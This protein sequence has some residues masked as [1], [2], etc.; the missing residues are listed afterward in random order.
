MT[1]ITE[2]A[3]DEEFDKMAE[4]Y[5]EPYV[6]PSVP[7]TRYCKHDVTCA[8]KAGFRKSESLRSVQWPSDDWYENA[9]EGFKLKEHR[10]GARAMFLI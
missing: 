10:Q 1:S 2:T 5:G 6:C 4:E 7:T 3:K 8:F 9:V